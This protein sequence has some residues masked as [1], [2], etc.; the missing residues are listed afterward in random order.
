[1]G[2][3]EVKMKEMELK[4]GLKEK[5][6]ETERNKIIETVELLKS[7]IRD[8]KDDIMTTGQRIEKV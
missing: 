2:R 5:E 4:T 1:M 6:K 8:I 3:L 7:Q